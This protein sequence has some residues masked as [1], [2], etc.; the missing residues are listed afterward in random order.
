MRSFQHT[1][2]YKW[3]AVGVSAAFILVFIILG[4]GILVYL[5]QD[6]FLSQ[7]SNPVSKVDTSQPT[8]PSTTT[9]KTLP[10]PIVMSVYTPTFVTQPCEFETYPWSTVECG[11]VTVPE[12][13]Y[14]DSA[15]TIQLAIALYRSK[16]QTPAPDP[17]VFLQDNPGRG[18]I[19]WTTSIYPSFIAPLLA[20]RDVIIIDQRGSGLSVPALDCPEVTDDLQENQTDDYLDRLRTCRDRLTGNGVNLATYTTAIA[21]ADVK[22]IAGALGYEQINLYGIVFG[23]RLAQVI[24]RDYP[25]IVRSAVLDSPFP[26]AVN[27][28]NQAAARADHALKT[29]FTNC[30]ADPQCNSAY[31]NLEDSF[32]NLAQQLNTQPATFETFNLLKNETVEI[33]VDG[34]RL[35]DMVIKTL[36]CATSVS[37]SPQLITN[38]RNGDN[39]SFKLTFDDPSEVSNDNNIGAWLSANCTDQVAPTTM[40]VMEA[41]LAAYPHLE[42]WAK[43]AAFGDPE[44]LFAACD[45]WPTPPY[46]SQQRKPLVSDIPTL[47]LTGEYSPTAPPYYGQQIA[48]KLPHS[49]FFNFVGLGHTPS[50][51]AIEQCPLAIAVSFLHNPVV[52]PDSNCLTEMKHPP[53]IVPPEEIV[54]ESF[55]DNLQGLTGL[56][57]VNWI[58]NTMGTYFRSN[59]QQ[60]DAT[61]L[62]IQT[63]AATPG[64]WIQSL[65]ESYGGVGLD[66]PLQESFDVRRANGLTWKLYTGGWSD[67]LVDVALTQTGE[68]TL[69]VA[70]FSHP[71]DRLHLYN[72]LLVPVIEALTP[73][74]WEPAKAATAPQAELVSGTCKFVSEERLSADQGETVSTLGIYYYNGPDEAPLTMKSVVFVTVMGL[75]ELPSTL[76]IHGDTYTL[77]KEGVSSYPIDSAQ[78]EASGQPLPPIVDV[79]FTSIEPDIEEPITLTLGGKGP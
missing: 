7:P 4:A 64:Q 65:N 21:A 20:E 62:V 59:D 70:L 8:P 50:L 76:T 78:I 35:V 54:L 45:L 36:C 47:I 48:E 17:I 73:V 14:G 22:D 9:E 57:P 31:P 53:F 25:E 37:Q 46:D 52:P 10:T 75:S 5:N 26:L 12:D 1:N 16:S 11:Y 27:H 44:I 68:Q 72:N 19:E 3:I 79:L 74:D 55:V 67:Y 34:T 51:N 69:L 24:M 71:N 6:T 63:N 29:L 23:A 58:D 61:S 2:S 32:Y 39:S 15:D 49:H 60:V 13:R 66:P 41:D 33:T 40:E 77:S 18:A 42:G 30:A 28:F 56:A 38:I 43:S